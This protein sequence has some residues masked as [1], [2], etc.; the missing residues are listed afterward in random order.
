MADKGR[1][2]CLD[3][4]SMCAR[5]TTN[6]QENVVLVLNEIRHNGRAGYGCA[7]SAWLPVGPV[8]IRAVV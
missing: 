6:L 8:S 7:A 3:R 1:D 5:A 2:F 4:A